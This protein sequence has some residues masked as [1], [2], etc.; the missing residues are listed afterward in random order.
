MRGRYSVPPLA[1]AEIAEIIWI[2]RDAHFL[3]HGQRTD[4]TRRPVLDRPQQPA[5]FARQLDARRLADAEL[6]DR[7]VE[8]R[9]AQLQR[10]LDRAHVA[11]MHQNLVDAQHPERMPVVNQPPGHQ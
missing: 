4:R 6:A 9:R 3:P 7:V 8:P 11:R 1:T 10:H 5:I 2:G